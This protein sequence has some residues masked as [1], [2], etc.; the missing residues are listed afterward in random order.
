M[1]K[2]DFSNPILGRKWLSLFQSSLRF[3][4][5]FEKNVDIGSE[6]LGFSFTSNKFGLRGPCDV[7]ANTVLSGTSYAMGMS[8][9]KGYNWYELSPRFCEVFNIGMPMSM[10][11]QSNVLN[12]YFV[13]NRSHLIFI[14]HPNF[15]L[16]AKQFFNS[17][18][19][20]KDIASFMSWKTSQKYLPK[21]LIRWILKTFV[22]R[23]TSKVLYRKI[24][25]QKIKLDTIYSKVDI[26]A[27]MNFVSCEMMAIND[28]LASFDKVTIVRVPIKEQIYWKQTSDK[29]LDS[30]IRNFDDNWRL[31]TSNVE[32]EFSTLDLVAS[33]KFSL[34][35]YLP[36]DTHW[37]RRGNRVFHDSITEFLKTINL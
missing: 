35:H 22:K 21:L 26:S 11:E 33:N 10:V 4:L 34:A 14:Y 32:K 1:K 2:I 19:S 28:L 23:L 25:A 15:W 3:G 31:F 29:R 30:L 5:R 6:Y 24:D 17:R 16:I 12:K 13:G 7:S 8:V 27:D 18:N 36:F 9:D 20:K 37:N